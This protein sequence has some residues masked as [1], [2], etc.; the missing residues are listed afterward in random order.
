MEVLYLVT[1]DGMVIIDVQAVKSDVSYQIQY[2]YSSYSNAV[3]N[4]VR[5]GRSINENA[6]WDTIA[7]IIDKLLDRK[8]LKDSNDVIRVMQVTDASQKENHVDV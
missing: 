3:A 1:D 5:L 8:Y 2:Q 4:Y 6:L 7:M